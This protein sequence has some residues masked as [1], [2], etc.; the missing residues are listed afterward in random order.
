MGRRRDGPTR[1]PVEVQQ[2]DH[3]ARPGR[4]AGEQPHQ[5]KQERQGHEKDDP[6][7]EQM[8]EAFGQLRLPYSMSTPV[9]AIR[10][11]LVRP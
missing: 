9:S 5:R 2:I 11:L 3:A 7:L 8:Q 10:A 1:Q 6:A 4:A